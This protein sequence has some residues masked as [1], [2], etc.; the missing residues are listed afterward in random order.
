MNPLTSL[1]ELLLRF[2]SDFTFKK[3]FNLIFLM[4]FIVVSILIF[5]R[6]TAKF[7][8]DRIEKS[9]TIVERLNKLELSK[10]SDL[11]EIRG[12][13]VK[14]LNQ[15]ISP[16]PIGQIISMDN[17]PANLESASSNFF[18]WTLW[19]CI[20]CTMAPWLIISTY[21]IW[22]T[23]VEGDSLGFKGVMLCMGLGSLFALIGLTLPRN[24]WINYLAYPIG[25]FILFMLFVKADLAYKKNKK[26]NQLSAQK[27]QVT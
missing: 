22:K 11:I 9:L 16:M 10:D 24:P 1:A 2:L 25:H 18:N 12:K 15:A 26:M 8:L 20:L 27:K 19:S 3:Y 6:F 17:F 7:S 13:I 4:A 14:Q 5:D 21:G 23:I